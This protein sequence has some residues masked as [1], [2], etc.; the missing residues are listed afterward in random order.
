LRKGCRGRH[1]RR[2][3]HGDRQESIMIHVTA[4]AAAFIA[5]RGGDLTLYS[6]TLSG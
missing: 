3:A 1:G 6:K 2:A 4:Q 5:E